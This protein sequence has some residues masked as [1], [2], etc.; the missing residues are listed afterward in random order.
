MTALSVYI[1]TPC[2]GG[3]ICV[4]T[5]ISLMT[6]IANLSRHGIATG[7]DLRRANCY[8]AHERNFHVKRFLEGSCSHLLFVDADVSWSE[9]DA[10]LKML[11]CGYDVVGG[12]Y[13]HKSAAGD[14]PVRI[15]PHPVTGMTQVD[16]R[17]G[18][19]LCEGIPTGF[20]LIR[21]AALE[22]MIAAMPDKRYIGRGI[23]GSPTFY[24]LFECVQD[25][26]HWWG[27]DYTFCRRWRA[28]GGQIWA[29]PDISFAHHGAKDYTGNLHQWLM[30][31]PKKENAA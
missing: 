16:A 8:I 14:F 1:G 10:V 6:T 28:L 19:I 22:K 11:R 12:V 5:V 29:Y 17:T 13:P 15:I 3:Q 2:Y 9:P 7:P 24:N 30:A 23:E 20:M 26:D 27:E 31:Q 25:G 4:E 21:R 18:A